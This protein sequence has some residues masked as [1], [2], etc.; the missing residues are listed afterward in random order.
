[1]ETSFTL[2]T[3]ASQV[4][5]IFDEISNHHNCGI[6]LLALLR[7]LWWLK[8]LCCRSRNLENYHN[9]GFEWS[10]PTFRSQIFFLL[11]IRTF[12]NTTFHQNGT[13]LW[14]SRSKR[15]PA[16]LLLTISDSCSLMA[17]G[18]LLFWKVKFMYCSSF[19]P[20]VV[21]DHWPI[22]SILNNIIDIKLF[23][24]KLQVGTWAIRRHWIPVI[25]KALEE[26]AFSC[27]LG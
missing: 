26:E 11:G 16:I 3:S 23:L 4:R 14:T 6:F 2:Q 24:G 7:L 18:D 13:Y 20:V 25:S 10:F 12:W 27:H 9:E 5:T 22:G 8:N 21:F 1:M 19:S 17:P 15:R